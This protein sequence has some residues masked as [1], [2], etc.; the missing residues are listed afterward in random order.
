MSGRIH[1]SASCLSGTMSAVGGHA[2]A[3]LENVLACL[4][5]ALDRDRPYRRP[6]APFS[7]SVTIRIGQSA[8]A[9][10]T[11]RQYRRAGGSGAARTIPDQD[12][13]RDLDSIK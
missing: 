4:R 7:G 12:N 9:P 5:L 13:Y 11:S 10:L 1:R 2:L 6:S 3:D 8:R